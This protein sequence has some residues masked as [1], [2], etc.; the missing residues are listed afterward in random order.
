MDVNLLEGSLLAIET[1]QRTGT[2]RN[3]VQR[4]RQATRR[5]TPDIA[6]AIEDGTL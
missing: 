1:G 2:E 5:Q 4:L 6:R 3:N